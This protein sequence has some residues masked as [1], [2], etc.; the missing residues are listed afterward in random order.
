VTGT[1]DTLLA[2][3]EGT[4]L[5]QGDRTLTYAELRASAE[6]LAAELAERGVVA[7]DVVAVWLP[8]QLET[9]V[10]QFAVTRLGAA[11]LGVNTRYNRA[12]LAHLL[13]LTHPRCLALPADLLGID[14]RGRLRAALADSGAPAPVVAVVAAEAPTDPETFDVGAGAFGY[15][16]PKAPSRTVPAATDPAATAL[17]F[18]TSGSTGLPKLAGHDHA[19]IVRHAHATARTLA[20]TPDD[21][22]LAAV[23]L[24]GILGFVGAV[25]A[26]GGGGTVLLEDTFDPA[27]CLADM[28]RH[29][30][31]L[32]VGGDDLFGRLRD[33][34]RETPRDLTR[35]RW[36]G[37]GDFAGRVDEVAAWAAAEFDTAVCGIYGSSELF[38]LTTIRPLTDPVADRVRA[39]G[40]RVDPGIEFRAADPGTDDVL[41]RGELGELQFRGYPVATGYLGNPT[42]YAAA[43]TA[44]GWFRTGDLGTVDGDDT[45]TYVCRAGDALRLSGFLVEPAEIEHH[46]AAHPAVVTA[47]VVGVRADGRDVAVG[48]A[49]TDGSVDEPALREHCVAGLAKF[50]VPTRI[51]V[52]DELPTTSG[53]NGTKIRTTVLRE[54]AEQALH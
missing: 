11:V 10:W 47:K 6:D 27:G 25:A 13:A 5:I 4:A 40:T 54:W 7:G 9:V 42:A 37:I 3:R 52:V 19:A 31:T 20:V 15:T 21:V 22:M 24:V 14:F 28:E 34:A 23:P 38:A 17:A 30:V 32:A 33:A 18:T 2:G 16:V 8:N 36:A 43:L 41:P 48:F 45:L 51:L 50:K 53:T 1:L 39:G 49:L 46:L 29:G 12:E 35:W 44:D 26:I